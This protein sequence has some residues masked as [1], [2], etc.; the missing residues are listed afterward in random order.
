MATAPGHDAPVP[1]PGVAVTA[2]GLALR[3][4]DGPIVTGVHLTAPAGELLAVIGPAGSGRTSLL[5]A[6]GGRMRLRAGTAE[7]GTVRLRTGAREVRRRVAVARAQGAAAPDPYDKVGELLGLAGLYAGH[8]TGARAI[9]DALA[10]VGLTVVDH[11][12]SDE[13]GVLARSARYE[14]LHAAD[15][16]LLAVALALVG[17]PEVLLVDDVD[18]GQDDRGSHRVWTELRRVAESGTTV[19]ATA[20]GAMTAGRYAHRTVLLA[21]GAN[22]DGSDGLPRG[23]AR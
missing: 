21:H 9:G 12:K 20:S 3:G 17:A 7:V 22:D 11:P 23:G 10:A 1:A 13:P 8:R 4:S 18:E 15:R 14:H 2:A 5:L 6:L 16:L 19:I